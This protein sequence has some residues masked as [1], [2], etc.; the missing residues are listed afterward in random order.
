M[1]IL[2]I[3]GITLGLIITLG[4]CTVIVG[5]FVLLKIYDQH[6]PRNKENK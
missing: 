5:W 4:V 1:T 6:Y 3:S 2:K